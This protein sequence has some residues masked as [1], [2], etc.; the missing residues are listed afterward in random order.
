M[1]KMSLK[2]KKQREKPSVL[3]IVLFV[4]LVIYIIGL[5]IPIIWSIY[6]SMRNPTGYGKLSNTNYIQWFDSEEI[7][8]LFSNYINAF[9]NIKIVQ[10]E[11]LWII[12][13]TILI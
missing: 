12:H 11:I 7:Q 6:G 9:K 8:F 5:F 10:K 13:W 3:T 2:I 1:K 4:F